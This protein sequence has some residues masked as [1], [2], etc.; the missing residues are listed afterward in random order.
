MRQYYYADGDQQY[1]PFG[2][3]AL[4]SKNISKSTL[5][6]YEGLGD[7]TQA[8]NIQELGELFM[9]PPAATPDW[10]NP[11]TNTPPPRQ[12]PYPSQQQRYQPRTE[13]RPKSW[14]VESILVTIFCCLPFGIAGIVNAAKVDSSV[15]AGDFDGAERA[16][17]EAGK[18][19]KIAF[20][21]GIVIYVLYGIY[22]I[23]VL[24]SISSGGYGY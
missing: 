22:M 12:Q 15:A 17:Q 23:M 5:V 14:M 18:W 16:S 20:G 19:V 7:W 11:A 6:W 10:Q 1:G 13:A 4:K 3:E 9:A 8:G 24:G 2:F 21:L